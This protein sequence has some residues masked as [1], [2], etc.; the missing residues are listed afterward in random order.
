MYTGILIID[1]P[2]G[3]T[4]HDVVAHVRR[5]LGT[6]RVGHAGTLDPD[7]TGV[8][9]VCVGDSTRILEY[10]TADDKVYE[11]EVSFGIGTDTEDASG[12]TVEELDAS[13][14]DVASITRAAKSMVGHIE[15]RPP[16][17]SA[18]H[19]EGR[20]AYDLAR[21]GVDFE[22]PTREVEIARLEVIGCELGM[23]PTAQFHVCCSK[24]TYIRALCRD[25]GLALRVPAHMSQL[26][27]V[28]SGM[29]RIEDAVS[30]ADWEAD[31]NPSRWLR[32][33]VAGLDLPRVLVSLQEANRLA[34]G[35][36]IAVRGDASQLPGE[37]A[38]A[39]DDQE[40]LV[41]IVTRAAPRDLNLWKPRKVFWKRET[42]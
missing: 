9:V 15:Q 5:K 10:I 34:E 8:L 40:R 19:V 35:Q 14:L 23:Y 26:R 12:R 29:F 7:A 31:P 38:A 30:L 21:S 18:V 41:A 42:L 6:R 3:L 36:A 28:R 16:R 27:R 4:S 20:R 37:F 33:P 17:Y 39:V 1:K 11:G 24:G 2:A 22:L 25:W 13:H 32:P